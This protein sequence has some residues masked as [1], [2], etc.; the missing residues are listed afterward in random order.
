MGCGLTGREAHLLA[1]TSASW[2]ILVDWN[3][4]TWGDS[5]HNGHYLTCLPC[6]QSRTW[7]AWGRE[8]FR[9]LDSIPSTCEEMEPGSAQGF[10]VEG[11]EV[12]GTSWN[13]SF[14][15]DVKRKKKKIILR[16]TEY[17][18]RLPKI[19]VS[20]KDLTA[21]KLQARSSSIWCGLYFEQKLDLEISWCCFQHEW[22]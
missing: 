12:T 11:W 20:F 2:W 6:D 5:L 15:L 22:P 1:R 13:E 14:R 10:R 17:W 7:P 16:I 21:E 18:K 4:K 19:L 9:G 3:I 8:D